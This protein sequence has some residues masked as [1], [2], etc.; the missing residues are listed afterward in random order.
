MC[1]PTT[2]TTYGDE[3]TWPALSNNSVRQA[4]GPRVVCEDDKGAA[5]LARTVPDVV[6]YGTQ[7][8]PTTRSRR[9]SC[10]GRARVSRLS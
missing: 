6:T 10:P 3:K 8:R 2:W 1:R 4:P 5:A 9:S 7:S